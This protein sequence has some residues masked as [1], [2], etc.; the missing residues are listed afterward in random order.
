MLHHYWL[1]DGA[2]TFESIDDDQLRSQRLLRYDARQFLR[3]TPSASTRT[4]LGG[5]GGIWRTTGLGFVVALPHDAVVA[6]DDRFEF[7]LTPAAGDLA[8][9]TAMTLRPRPVVALVDQSGRSLRY[10]DR[11]PVLSNLTGTVRIRGTH[12][13]LFLSSEYPSGAGDNVEDLVASGAQLRQLT[14]DQPGAAF[15]QLGQLAQLPVYLHQGDAPV[16]VAPAGVAGAPERGVELTGGVPDD[17]LAVIRLSPQRADDNDF[18]FIE[19]N[20]RPREVFPVFEVHLKN[21]STIWRY[22]KKSDGSVVST[23]PTPR[24]MTYFGNAGT[25]RKP[26][27]DAIAVERDPSSP[28]RVAQLVSEI[29]V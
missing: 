23:E 14:S 11:T 29:F 18:S 28:E 5:L 19:A 22:R 21:R 24:P 6:A 1:D 9:Y 7:V 17:V 3:T 15:Q 12:K 8:T 2:T 10:K 25:Q 16:I 13:H 27:T 26:S 20:G 4:L